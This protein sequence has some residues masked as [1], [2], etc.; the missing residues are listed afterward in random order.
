MTLGVQD[1][2]FY[3]TYVF[4]EQTEE[5]RI[6]ISLPSEYLIETIDIHDNKTTSSSL[7]ILFENPTKEFIWVF[8]EPGRILEGNVTTRIPLENNPLNNQI[9]AND[10]FNYSR[11]GTNNNLQYGTRD[12]FSTL[13][14]TIA[15]NDRFETTDATY[16]RT[17]QPYKY[18]S[19]IPGGINKNEKKKYIY[20][21]SF[22]LQP[23]DYQPSGSFNFS[24]GED[25]TTFEFT[26]PATDGNI[27]G[28]SDYDLTIF[29]TR[30]EYLTF[31]FGRAGPY[32]I[33]YCQ[34]SFKQ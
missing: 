23:E 13:K 33:K 32:L 31:N 4:L 17:M 2:K 14:I 28:L 27:K 22:A 8:R 29:A 20:V 26:G 5:S 21:Y 18:H 30:Y 6:Q 9:N 12:P 10:I 11:A 24:I 7:N 15:N 25:Q 3:V 1:F 34:D 16:F 19:N